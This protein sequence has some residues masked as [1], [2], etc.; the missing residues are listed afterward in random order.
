[1]RRLPGGSALAAHSP[2]LAT[3]LSATPKANADPCASAQAFSMALAC[4]SVYGRAGCGERL[5]PFSKRTAD[6]ADLQERN[7]PIATGGLTPTARWFRIDVL[8][9]TCMRCTIDN[10]WNGVLRRVISG[11]ATSL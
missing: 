2:S 11:L 1:M 4:V 3:R 8:K 5:L 9:L 10:I 6:F 7:S